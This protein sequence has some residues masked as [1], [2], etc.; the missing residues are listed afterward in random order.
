MWSAA[1]HGGVLFEQPILASDV[2]TPAGERGAI[3]VGTPRLVDT[4]SGEI[5]RELDGCDWYWGNEDG[6]G[7][8]DTDCGS[9]WDECFAC[10]CDTTGWVDNWGDGCDWYDA[11]P[12]G[13]GYYDEGTGS[14]AWDECCACW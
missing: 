9:A 7:W 3:H 4:A 5:I 14:S 11:N 6:C 1:L 12:S 8:Y 13:C 10:W 2:T